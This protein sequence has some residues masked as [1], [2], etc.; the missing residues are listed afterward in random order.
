[1]AITSRSAVDAFVA[2]VVARDIAGAREL[3]HDEVDFRAMTPGRIWEADGPG[4]V[5][6]TLRQWLADPD[7]EI[8]EVAPTDPVAVE[9]TLRVGWRVSGTDGDGPF[10]FEQQAYVREQ[11]GRVAWMRVFCSGFR[12]PA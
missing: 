1:M 6:E 3:L 4:D 11:D 10:V 7:E 12:R 8:H 9:D 5:E 2:A